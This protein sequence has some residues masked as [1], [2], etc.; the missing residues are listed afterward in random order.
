MP[1]DD[2]QHVLKCLAGDAEAFE[3]LVLRY[4]NA[5]YATA[6]SYAR[7][8]ADAQDIVQDAF[9]T[10]YCKLSQLRDPKAFGGWLRRIVANNCRNWLRGR[11]PVRNQTCSLDM[12]GPDLGRAAQAQHAAQSRGRDLWDAVDRL[13][14]HYRSVALMHY[15][16]GM[17][18]DEIAA[19]LGVPV[20]TVRGRLQQSRIRLREALLPTEREELDM[21]RVDMAQQVQ[22]TVCRIA[23]RRVRQII[24]MDD[25]DHIVLFCGV[26]ADIEIRSS[27]G[28]DA[29][30]EGTL[31]SIGPTDEAAQAS[32]DG[33]DILA[34]QVDSFLEQGPHEGEVFTGTTTDDDGNPIGD[35]CTTGA[36]WHKGI[37]KVWQTVNHNQCAGDLYPVLREH[38]DS[39]PQEISAS[40]GKA[41]RVSIVRK[42][43]ADLVLPQEVLTEDIVRIFRT[44]WSGNGLV[45]G[46]VGLADLV[47][48]VPASRTVTLIRGRRVQVSGPRKAT[49]LINISQVEASDVEGDVVL[50]NSFLESARSIKGKLYQRFY[51]YGGTN[52]SDGQARRWQ[53]M[54]CNIEGVDGE[55]DI[56]VGRIGI[57]A[58]NLSGRVRIYNRYGTTRLYQSTVQPDD[59]F[60]IE[61]CSGDVLLFLKDDLIGKANLTANTLCGTLSYDPLRKLGGL[62]TNNDESLVVLS[63]ITSSQ[64]SVPDVLDCEFYVSTESGNVTIEKMK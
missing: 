25:V 44:N 39:L 13:P 31:S 35:G 42:E 45:H 37:R 5:A 34:D 55:I 40:L 10:A 51:R 41:A 21:A 6:L 20:S 64:G 57:E 38:M 7:N 29:V 30:L 4:Q 24:P 3:P 47:L 18:Y 26:S 14:D 53:Q 60:H 17:P 15:L 43:M 59:R 19:F 36:L 9:V 56:D 54:E 48:S 12:A 8:R 28:G 1:I 22:E 16:S 33:I 52:W 23:T 62:T 11:Q 32:V 27:G 50:F 49:N 61:T 63:T 58:S 46:S 2:S